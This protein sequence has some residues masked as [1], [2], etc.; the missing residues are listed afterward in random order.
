M[1]TGAHNQ[2][3][4]KVKPKPKTEKRATQIKRGRPKP[5]LTAKPRSLIDYGPFGVL[6]VC[7]SLHVPFVRRSPALCSS[8]TPIVV[9]VGA[10]SASHS[11]APKGSPP[12]R[13]TESLFLRP[14]KKTTLRTQP[15]TTA[16]SGVWPEQEVTRRRCSTL[17]LNTV[18]ILSHA[19]EKKKLGEV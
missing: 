6:D 12:Q 5:L 19:K 2:N 16:G 9:V 1:K 4:Q 17:V 18:N 13:L 11:S 7:P 15:R 14:E 10:H 3:P 8:L